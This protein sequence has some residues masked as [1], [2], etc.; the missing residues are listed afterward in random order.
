MCLAPRFPFNWR[1]IYT[2][3]PAQPAGLPRP[4]VTPLPAHWQ[5]QMHE[6]PPR[7]SQT[8]AVAER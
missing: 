5:S 7:N 1:T 6:R 8:V 3:A 4:V 2:A